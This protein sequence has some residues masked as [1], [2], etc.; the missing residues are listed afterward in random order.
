MPGVLTNVA[1]ILV[2]GGVGLLLGQKVNVRLQKTMTQGLALCILL[3]GLSGALDGTDTI[4]AIV[5]MVLGAIIGEALDIERRLD[6]LGEWVQRRMKGRG[7][8]VSQGFV[9]ASLLF[10]VGAM[11]V[12]GSLDAGLSGKYDTLFAKSILDGV[13]ALLFATTLGVGVLFSAV[14]ILIYQGA[15][16]LLAG[17][18][19][20]LL[21]DAVVALMSGTGGLLIAGLGLNMLGIEKI[22]VGNLLPAIFVP[23]IYVPVVEWAQT[24]IAAL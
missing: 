1:A 7:S 10:C 23:I 5:C 21:S 11:A 15:I 2:G 3:I 6:G 20:P 12:V 13:S 9:T 19:Q 8:N 14:P 18:M 22:K 4:G 16:A 17:L 24:V